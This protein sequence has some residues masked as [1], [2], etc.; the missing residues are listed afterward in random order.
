[1]HPVLDA[2]VSTL[3]LCAGLGFVLSLAL[4]VRAFAALLLLTLT[5]TTAGVLTL[6]GSAGWVR[7]LAWGLP[8]LAA[9]GPPL[10]AFGLGKLLGDIVI[11]ACRSKR[12]PR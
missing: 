11:A 10:S 9:L 2:S 3:A 1:M 4:T 7:W 6:D 8:Q 5:A 12:R